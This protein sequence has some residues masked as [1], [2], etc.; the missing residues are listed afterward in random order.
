MARILVVD[1]L[2]TVRRDIRQ[3]LEKEGHTVLEA[4]D[5]RE[6]LEL[7]RLVSVDL[8][9][10]DIFMPEVDGMELIPEL[11]RTSRVPIIAMTG[12]HKR[13]MIP[14]FFLEVARYLGAV[15]TIEKPFDRNSFLTLVQTVLK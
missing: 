4:A 5:G 6:A 9:V 12:A 8:V 10:T 11:R 3:W 15:H 1:D 7:A 13:G 14:G 2:E